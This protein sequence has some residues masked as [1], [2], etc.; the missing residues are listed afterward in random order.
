[1]AHA[2]SGAGC[3]STGLAFCW[4]ALTALRCMSDEPDSYGKDCLVMGSRL[5]D[6]SL[7]PTLAG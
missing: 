5:H 4:H 2:R 3:L 7:A 1:M 6:M